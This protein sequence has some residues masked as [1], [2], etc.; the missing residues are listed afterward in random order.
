MSL[1]CP[2]ASGAATSENPNPDNLP[3]PSARI[4]QP[5]PAAE[6]CPLPQTARTL[7]LVEDD[8]FIRPLLVQILTKANFHVLPAENGLAGIELYQAKHFQIHGA[9]I[10]I[11]LPDIHGTEVFAEIRRISPYLPVVLISGFSTAHHL[12]LTGPAKFLQKPF[13][14]QELLGTLEQLLDP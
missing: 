14:P 2:V 13:N 3:P 11:V 7:L 5:I 10:D 1:A 12:N 9:I 8:P 4:A 6:T